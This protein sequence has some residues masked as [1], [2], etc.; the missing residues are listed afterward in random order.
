LDSASKEIN[1]KAAILDV[2]E[3][4]ILAIFG[5]G[6]TIKIITKGRKTCLP[7]IVRTRYV[8]IDHAIYVLSG[9]RT[10]DWVL[11]ALY[12]SEVIIRSE[13]YLLKAKVEEVSEEEKAKAFEAFKK[14]YGSLI[15][16]KWYPISSSRCLKLIPLGS[17]TKRG[18]IKGE[19]QVTTTYEAWVSQKN[20]YLN[21]VALAFD[22]AAEEYD[23]TISNNYINT[24]IRKKTI[25]ELL[26]YVSP[27]HRL[28]EIGCGTGQEAVEISRY[29]K[30]IIATDVSK[31]MIELLSLKVRAKKLES[32]I[33]P[34]RLAASEIDKISEMFPD[35][36]INGCYSFNGPLNCEPK[37]RT[38]VKHLWKIL[39]PPGYFVCS[40]RNTICATEEISHIFSLQLDKLSPRKHQPIMVSVGGMDIPAFYYTPSIFVNIF[41]P[42]FKVEK[43]IGLPTFLPPA[44]LNDYYVRLRQYTSLLEKIDD[45]LSPHFPFN[46][47]GDQNLFVFK[48]VIL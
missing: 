37:I 12:Y 5:K 39:E 40:I 7:H 33:I 2:L 38:F 46:R 18:L 16:K 41:K 11:N 26:K 13:D 17:P 35:I 44:Y 47:F 32:K 21:S 42:Y 34:V 14:K 30:T 24:W 23:F 22:S 25:K 45:L 8:V 4:E 6:E 31:K 3:N 1:F 9:N 20:D 10:A 29:V 27:E 28:L 15:V 43:I 36:K 19:N 48:K